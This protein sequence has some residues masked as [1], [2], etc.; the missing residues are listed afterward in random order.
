MNLHK[1]PPKRVRKINPESQAAADR[2]VA[3]TYYAYVEKLFPLVNGKTVVDS[4]V[5]GSGFVLF[6]DDQT[7]VQA[8]IARNQIRWDTGNGLVPKRQLARLTAPHGSQH[9]ASPDDPYAEENCDVKTEIS[10]SHGKR[11]TGLARGESSFNFCFPHKM[12]LETYISKDLTYS[13][14]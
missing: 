11:I 1:T 8:Y 13:Y 6:F 5:G 2:I 7:W 4:M 14:G 3:S 10:K 12:E 9:I